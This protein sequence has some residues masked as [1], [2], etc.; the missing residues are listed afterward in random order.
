M[1]V[2]NAGAPQG[3][4]ASQIS[5]ISQ[6][7]SNCVF[8]MLMSSQQESLLFETQNYAAYLD[9]RPANPGQVLLIPKQHA[10]LI[11]QLKP[12]N[13][14]DMLIGAKNISKAMLSAFDVQGT[15]IIIKAGVEAGQTIAHTSMSIIPR[16]DTDGLAINLN[17]DGGQGC[18]ICAM[19]GISEVYSAESAA[20]FQIEG[21]PILAVTPRAHYPIFEA[22]PDDIIPQ[23]AS[24]I[25]TSVDAIFNEWNAQAAVVLMQNGVPAGQTIPHFMVMIIPRNKDDNAGFNLPEKQVSKQD[26]ARIKNALLGALGIKGNDDHLNQQYQQKNNNQS[27][28]GQNAFDNSNKQPESPESATDVDRLT[29]LQ[30]FVDEKKNQLMKNWGRMP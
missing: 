26:M 13:L 2:A 11:T 3:L 21:Q 28:N 1:P 15:S 22:A 29:N 18:K 16:Y 20:V 12:E 23:L 24:L 10:P 25:I 7:S 5:Q 27:G 4:Q 17:L 8:C 6:A 9:I 14:A 19:D 30:S